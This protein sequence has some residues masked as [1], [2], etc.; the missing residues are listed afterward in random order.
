MKVYVQQDVVVLVLNFQ[1]DF[2]KKLSFIDFLK[3]NVFVCEDE[4]K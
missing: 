1:N 4:F 2:V 3:V